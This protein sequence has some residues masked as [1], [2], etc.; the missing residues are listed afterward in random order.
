[1]PRRSLL[2]LAA[3]L[4]TGLPAV[5]AGAASTAAAN[6]QVLPQR[7]AMPELGRDRTLRLYLPPSYGSGNARYPVVY[8]HDGQNLFDAATAYAGEWG[9]DEA[10]NEMAQR[11]GFEAIVVGIDNGGARR[12]TELNP[13]DHPRFGKGE[14]AAYLQ[15]LVSVVKPYI[16]N[17][18]RSLP[19]RE[20]TAVVG[21]SMG[22]VISHAAILRYP[23]VF[24]L[25]GVLSPAYWTAP[26]MFDEVR[27]QPLPGDARVYLSMGELEGQ[28][29][30][31][32]VSR[33]QALMAKQAA[34][35]TL[36]RV[37]GAE[38]NEAAWR[39]EFKTV[40]NW[41]FRLPVT[42]AK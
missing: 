21:S 6:V 11:Q 23:Q 14:G 35:V 30:N 28:E 22:G 19:G 20:H 7:F 18:Y 29:A 39:A 5:A 33:M 2:L 9:V 1:M 8:M 40:L 36:H 27:L 37:P 24:G 38:H 12:M 41:L 3:W 25:A 4:V 17:H 34:A 31:S 10:L 32:D 42:A 13:Y 16:D 15:F 26:G